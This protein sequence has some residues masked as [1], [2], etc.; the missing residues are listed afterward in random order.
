MK[1]I[2]FSPPLPELIL[3]WEKTTTWRINDD[4]DFQVW[5]QVSLLTQPECK[6]FAQ[7]KL[8]EVRMTTFWKLSSEDYDGHEEFESEEQMKEVYKKYY[9]IEIT[10]ETPLKIIKFKLI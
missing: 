6:E 10:P 3:T 2:K 8:T 9:N 5:D 7:A 4:K 1:T